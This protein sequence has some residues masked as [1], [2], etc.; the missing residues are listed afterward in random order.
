MTTEVIYNEL[1]EVLGALS[2]FNLSPENGLKL[3]GVVTA[4]YGAKSGSVP[5]EK[6][7]RLASTNVKS[8]RFGG[9]LKA[10]VKDGP[11]HPKDLIEP[12]KERRIILADDNKVAFTQVLQGFQ[13]S[14]RKVYREYPDGKWG[15]LSYPSPRLIEQA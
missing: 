4:M 1:S 14:K 13:K 11:K 9:E 3:L 15:L 12:L 5:V 7:K 2:K 8:V 6:K 10:L